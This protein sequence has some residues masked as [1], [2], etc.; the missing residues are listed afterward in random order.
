M[1]RSDFGN[2]GGSNKQNEGNV[3]YTRRGS[4]IDRT[5]NDMKE[6]REGGRKGE[7]MTVEKSNEEDEIKKDPTD[8]G[9]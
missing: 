8:D 2:V 3:R 7:G 6:W 1:K 9:R 4:E 5:N